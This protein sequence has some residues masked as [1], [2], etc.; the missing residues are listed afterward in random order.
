M[1]QTAATFDPGC[2]SARVLLPLT[3][4]VAH[5]C[6]ATGNVLQAAKRT[7]F[8]AAVVCD[9]SPEASLI[10]LRIRRFV[11]PQDSMHRQPAP[12]LLAAALP[13][14]PWSSL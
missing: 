1:A 11:L 3:T 2:A 4:T 5:A 10:A 13:F 7:S 6:S 12:R 14:A 9:L 8:L